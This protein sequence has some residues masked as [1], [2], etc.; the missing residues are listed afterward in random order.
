MRIA[1]WRGSSAAFPRLRIAL[2]E[3]PGSRL[4]FTLIALDLGRIGIIAERA[5]PGA[6]ADL[7]LIDAVAPN[8][9]ATWYLT[10]LDCDADVPC[11]AATQAKL[12]QSRLVPSLAERARLLGEVDAA[13]ARDTP[14]IPI[15][16]PVRWSL[17]RPSLRGF[18]TNI[19]ATHP[20][21]R[22]LNE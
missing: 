15:A 5:P 18:R 19:R 8:D 1:A 20:L 9:S 12:D 3:G 21:H 16:S 13:Y 2:P 6:P 10:R 7:R 22:L 14:F 4:L 11:D 17:V